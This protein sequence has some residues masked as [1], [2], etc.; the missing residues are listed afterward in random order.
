M[1]S[2]TRPDLG[3]P[4]FVRAND[5]AVP[6]SM[7]LG[8]NPSLHPAGVLGSGVAWSCGSQGAARSWHQSGA[9]AAYHQYES[10]EEVPLIDPCCPERRYVERGKKPT[11]LPFQAVHF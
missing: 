9:L 2:R 3:I 1:D 5:R 7:L 8:S 11:K 10:V 4:P 6:I